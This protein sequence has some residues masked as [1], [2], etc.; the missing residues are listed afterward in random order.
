M[1]FSDFQL[2]SFVDPKPVEL[3]ESYIP[4]KFAPSLLF[5]YTNK[6]GLQ[7]TD[8]PNFIFTMKQGSLEKTL[9]VYNSLL[10]Q[11]V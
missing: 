7:C 6:F 4:L 9:E 10:A 8:T 1:I 3:G 2:R 11:V 5:D